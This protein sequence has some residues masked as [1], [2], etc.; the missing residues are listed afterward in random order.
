VNESKTMCSIKGISTDVFNE[1][2]RRL[3]LKGIIK[4]T[5]MRPINS[6]LFVP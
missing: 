5:G 6:N 4:E 3:L 2:G 1:S